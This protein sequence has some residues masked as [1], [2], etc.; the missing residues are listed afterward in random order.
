MTSTKGFCNLAEVLITFRFLEL[1]GVTLEY[2]DWLGSFEPLLGIDLLEFLCFQD[3]SDVAGGVK[4][5]DDVDP[6]R[7]GAVEDE[8]VPEPPDTGAAE[9]F[10]AQGW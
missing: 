4:D 10:Q 8:I 5:P 1:Y 7:D 3:I 2:T 9:T 6:A